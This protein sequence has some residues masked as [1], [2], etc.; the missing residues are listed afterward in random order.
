M[1]FVK[2]SIRSAAAMLLAI[3]IM[4]PVV[5]GQARDAYAAETVT[6]YHDTQYH[7]GNWSTGNLSVDGG[8]GTAFCVQPSKD[9]PPNGSYPYEFMDHDSDMRKVLYYLVGGN[10][11]EDVTSETLFS[12]YDYVD[13]Y[14]TSHVLLSWMWDGCKWNGDADEGIG[15]DFKS[16]IES[17]YD[18]IM[19]LP[20][21]PDAFETFIVE[22][23]DGY[24]TVVGS[25][26]LEDVDVSIQKGS[27]IPAF[28]EGNPLYSLEGTVY[29]I[30]ETEIDAEFDT[31]AIAKLTVKEDGASNVVSLK[32]GTYYYRET[33]AGKG[34][35]LDQKIHS[36]EITTSDSMTQ[37]IWVED[38]PQY[39]PVELLLTKKYKDGKEGE[40]TGDAS[41]SGAE[42]TVKYYGSAKATGKAKYTWVFQTDEAGKIHY[43]DNYKKSGPELLK[44]P[45]GNPVLP[46]G[47]VTVQETKAPSGYLLND[48]IYTIPINSEGTGE[49]VST[50]Q[51]P[52]IDEDVIRGGVSFDKQDRELSE[53]EA[54]GGASLGDISF[55]LCNESEHAVLVDGK[56]YQKGDVIDQ[57][58]TDESG[59]IET[60]QDLLPY[61][62]YSLQEIKTN[63][64]YLLSDAEKH[65]FLIR[66][67][68]VIVT[69]D[70]DENGLVFRN[71]VV[72]ND[73]SFHKIEDSTNKRMGMVAF[74]LTQ[75]ETGEQ[76]VIVTNK[77]G[78]FSSV[79][80]HTKETNINDTVLK[81]YD[82]DAVIPTSA[83]K[84]NTG[85][86]FGRGQNGSES[87]PDDTL[88]A[89]PYGSY[90]LSELRCEANQGYA[91]LKDIV[92][93]IEEDKAET[94]VIS[95]GTLTNDKTP[96]T[97]VV[98]IKTQARDEDNETHLSNADDKVTIID[99]VL[100]EGVKTDTAYQ[101]EGILMDRTTGQPLLI[102]GKTV[103]A[104]K[105]ITPTETKGTAE[106]SFTLNG[107][108]LAGKDI[109]VFETIK[110]NGVPVASH[111]DLAD[112]DQ[113][114]HFPELK[115]TAVDKGNNKSEGSRI[116]TDTVSYHNLI[117]GKTYVVKGSLMDKSTKKPVSDQKSEITGT[118]VFTPD[119]PD[120]KINVDFQFDATGCY[121]RELVAF[122]QL[123]VD[124][125]KEKTLI[126][127]HED[128]EDEKQTVLLKGPEV[129][130]NSIT[131][132]TVEHSQTI[133]TKGPKTGDSI[134]AMFFIVIGVI[135]CSALV[136]TLLK[137]KHY[138]V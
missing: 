36:V 87:N 48:S 125:V 82:E 55:A 94:P 85:I 65:Y 57:F 14:V 45:S 31:N 24:Q 91:L 30:Y 50:Y 96:E 62:T 7:Y 118:V 41:L 16:R 99:A 25:W 124:E 60:K 76:H 123:Y 84:A 106:L 126:A 134:K 13:I 5:F 112:E 39:D 40:T 133:E 32:P 61:G 136:L 37:T 77:N 73:I 113:M 97:P 117:P 51:S 56:S 89:L 47:T 104:K 33:K 121:D 53:N 21:P 44:D 95:L 79:K 100:F 20:D 128:F 66:E 127:S 34:Y 98:Q 108:S 29:G 101:I 120:G 38:I 86:W 15:S 9:T 105:E 119:K 64:A 116:I 58:T 22:G 52:V 137:R 18:E 23:D 8:E 67:N 59:H 129:K 90:T 81:E 74:L 11:Y 135:A 75:N 17:I 1:K 103:T 19:K 80:D 4:L 130:E 28:T 26:P 92:F 132:T 6:L 63:D 72:R 12:E 110:E 3:V 114:I 69:A 27:L 10:G 54:L 88:G 46:L 78:Y 71:Q 2:I 49:K 93:Y 122:E 102:D 35:A 111:E 115:T 138:S 109:V 43:K 42:F 131:K 107:S 68:N 83:L 70:R